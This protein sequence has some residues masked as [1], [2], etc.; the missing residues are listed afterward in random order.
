MQRVTIC[1]L[2]ELLW[3]AEKPFQE[4]RKLISGI[5]VVRS[6]SQTL[7]DRCKESVSQFSNTD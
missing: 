1:I 4:P 6:G 5:A 2:M 7:L 3:E